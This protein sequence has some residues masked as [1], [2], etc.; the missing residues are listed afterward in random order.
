M[1]PSM[2]TDITITPTGTSMATTTAMTTTGTAMTT[3]T[4]MTTTMGTSTAPGRWRS[5]RRTRRCT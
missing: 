5:T 1:T 2:V 4:V 3:D